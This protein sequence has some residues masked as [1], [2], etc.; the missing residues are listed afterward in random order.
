M[1][2][3]IHT[4]SN[5]VLRARNVLG[6]ELVPIRRHVTRTADKA[7]DQSAPLTTADMNR[8]FVRRVPGTE[9]YILRNE[10]GREEIWVR[11]DAAGLRLVGGRGTGRVNVSFKEVLGMTEKRTN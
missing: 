4:G 2:G 10:E 6:E 3:R 9:E 1:R 5:L 8:W 7:P 11:D